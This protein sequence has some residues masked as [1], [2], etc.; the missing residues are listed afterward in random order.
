RRLSQ[1]ALEVLAIVAYRQPIP[2]PEIESIRGVNCDEVIQSLL[3]KDL[4]AITGR[5]DS[6]GRPLLFG[7]T[8]SFL[9]YFGLATLKDLP[10]PREIDELLEARGILP[11]QMILEIPA[12][13]NVQEIEGHLAPQHLQGL[14]EVVEEDIEIAEDVESEEDSDEE[15][16]DLP[17]GEHSAEDIPQE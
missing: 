13:E 17:S 2:K 15:E 12:E 1:A 4:I 5:A 3:E 14:A 6:V 11:E 10:R 8:D 16:S 7:T 9:K